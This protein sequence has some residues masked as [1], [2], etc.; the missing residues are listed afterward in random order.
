MVKIIVRIAVEDDYT[1]ARVVG[2][3]IADDADQAWTDEARH[4][5]HGE[6]DARVSAVFLE[7]VVGDRDAVHGGRHELDDRLVGEPT[8]TAAD[9]RQVEVV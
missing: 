9:D 8:K 7:N 5:W 3:S 2:E 6:F 1:R 4:V